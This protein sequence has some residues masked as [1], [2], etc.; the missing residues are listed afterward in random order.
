MQKYGSGVVNR[1]CR[2]YVR[3]TFAIMLQLKGCSRL[4]RIAAG[5]EI[6]ISALE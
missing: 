4:V 3:W 5:H 2:S 1:V 6:A